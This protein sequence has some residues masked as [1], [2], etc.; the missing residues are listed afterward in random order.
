MARI[1]VEDCTEK[2]PN[3]FEL[4]RAAVLRTRQLK[5]GSRPIVDS[6][7]REVVTALRE[8]AAGH[9]TPVYPEDPPP[10]EGEAQESSE[11]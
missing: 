8:I 7:N 9:V 6:E 4:I 10:L 1:T 5:R 3:R 11:A 2:I